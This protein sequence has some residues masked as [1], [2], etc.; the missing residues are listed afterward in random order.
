MKPYFEPNEQEREQN[1]KQPTIAHK[2]IAKLVKDGYIKLIITTNF[3]RLIESALQGEGIDPTVV[4]HPNDIDGIVPL[5]HNDFTL[6][7][8]NGDYLDSRF[9]NTK[10]ELAKY[11]EKLHSF[12]L[13]IFNEFGIISSGWSAKWD[14]GLI[15]ILRQSENYRFSSFWTYVGKCEKELLEISNLRK[16][17]VVEIVNADTFCVEIAEKIEALEKIN[18][19]HP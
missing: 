11:D 17:Q 18:D 6:V 19:T 2:K 9:L 16:G 8:I 3:D 5:V 15:N 13:R 4:R 7:K 10:E 1:L 12:L 14:S